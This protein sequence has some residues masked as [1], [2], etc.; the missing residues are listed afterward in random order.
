[1]FHRVYEIVVKIPPGR[2]MTYGQIAEILDRQISP[3]A[4]GWALSQC[5]ADLP[6]QRVVNGRGGCSLGERQLERLRQEGIEFT[7]GRLDLEVYRYH[8]GSP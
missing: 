6:W 8:Q 7:Q 5:P 2:V 4:V 3:A 1:M